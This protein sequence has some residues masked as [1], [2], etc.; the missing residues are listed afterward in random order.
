M[1]IVVDEVD[2]SIYSDIVL[3]P[4]EINCIHRGEMISGEV[5]FNKVKCYIGIRLQGTWEYFDDEDEETEEN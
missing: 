3:S 2:K 4:A 5:N 1:Q